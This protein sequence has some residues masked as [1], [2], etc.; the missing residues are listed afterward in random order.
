M[1][2]AAAA[3]RVTERVDDVIVAAK[4]ISDLTAEIYQM[5]KAA[6]DGSLTVHA[7]TTVRC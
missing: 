1:E 3:K 7:A 4:T 6:D 5:K 2:V